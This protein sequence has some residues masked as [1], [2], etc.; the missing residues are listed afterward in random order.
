MK[1][2]LASTISFA[3]DHG[4]AAA[5]AR[6]RTRPLVLAYHRVVDDFASI[7]RTGMP[8]M[9]TSTGM[10]ERH[11]DSL[12][13]HFR[14]VTLDD[15]GAQ[16]LSGRPFDK[17]VAAVTFDDGYQDVYEQAYPVLT[18]KGIP[19]AVFVVTDLIGRSVWQV[20][21]RLYHLVGRAFATWHDP[22]RELCALLKALDLSV[23]SSIAQTREATRT[24]LLTV[25]ALLPGLPMADVQ[26]VMDGLE[27]SVGQG[28]SDIP[29][30]LGWAELDVMRRGGV[31]I[32][33]HTKRHV[34]LPAESAAT[35]ADELSG[36]KQAL[37]ARLGESIVHFAYP[38]GQ[39]TPS[40][41][42][43]VA[44]ADYRFAYTACQHGDPHHRALTIE[45]LLLWEGSSV[46]ADGRFSS[47]LLN[48]QA[49]DLWPPSRQCA[50]VHAGTAH[51]H[52]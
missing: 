13:R 43:A 40:V 51:A 16:V 29:R 33:S 39:F 27:A 34:S 41:I 22:H 4:F 30:T 2:T 48:C 47:A 50:R 8:S 35:V 19:A 5:L 11:L 24:P 36:S 3:H 17:P 18:R 15:I 38:G 52:G 42:E 1:T 31:T 46:D 9:L 44:Q 23:D 12:A 37:E 45:R 7:A 21:D 32:G 28:V 26:R 10:F 20:H 6:G 49:Q 14:F 25:S